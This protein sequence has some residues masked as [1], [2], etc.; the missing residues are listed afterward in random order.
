MERKIGEIFEFGGE[1][2]QCVGGTCRNCS[3]YYDTVCKNIITIGSTN[4][5]NCHCS[6]RTDHKSVIFKKLEKVGEPVTVKG[7]TF[8]KLTSDNNSCKECVFNVPN[9][10]CC[11]NS[12]IEGICDDNG[13]WVEIKQNKEGMEEKKVKL[14]KLV[15]D[16]TSNKI[17]YKEFEVEVKM[18]YTDKEESKPSLKSFS[19]E[20][21]KQGKPVCTRDGRKA[22]II[23]FDRCSNKPIVALVTTDDRE[24][25]TE[26]Y[27][28]G[29]IS[30]NSA[31]NN[32]LMMY[33]EK[34]E[35][36]VNV[37]KERCY[38]SKGEA[39]SCRACNMECI[40]TIRVEWEE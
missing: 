3:F 8:Q 19:L 21:A 6:L 24:Y 39:I 38:E 25:L 32:D 4:F 15:T 37:Y 40:D 11:K 23:C 14:D 35:G 17:T 33:P 31:E 12:Y 2:Y 27:C 22:R 9:K 36:W 16:Y 20:A 5:G 29:R 28:D 1:W 7:R 18:L 30:H 10:A 13:F 34:K 26:Y